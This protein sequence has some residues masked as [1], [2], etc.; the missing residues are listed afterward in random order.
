MIVDDNNTNKKL[1]LYLQKGTRVLRDEP[2]TVL[3]NNL[4]ILY[5]DRPYFGEKK[6]ETR[7]PMTESLPKTVKQGW[8][9]LF[10]HQTSNMDPIDD[11]L[12]GHVGTFM[13]IQPY[14]MLS[15]DMHYIAR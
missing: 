8:G 9:D 15:K 10:A 11:T 13:S 12:R 2:K 14:T 6:N 7:G 3:S 1:L 5:Q 4:A